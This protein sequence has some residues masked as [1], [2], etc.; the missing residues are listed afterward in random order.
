MGEISSIKS[1]RDLHHLP[2]SV[3]VPPAICHHLLRPQDSISDLDCLWIVFGSEKCFHV[4]ISV[5]RQ[6]S[7]EGQGK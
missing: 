7:N 2:I 6:T 1:A 3:R 4:S 5:I